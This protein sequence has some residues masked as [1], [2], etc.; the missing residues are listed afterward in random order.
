MNIVS[1][2]SVAIK[3]DI[4]IHDKLSNFSLILVSLD[5]DKAGIKASRKWWLKNYP[6]AKRLPVPF[7]KDPSEAYQKGLDIRAWI[8]AGLI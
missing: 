3:P 6:Q 2:G 1:L 8:Q 7:G 4:T 5:S